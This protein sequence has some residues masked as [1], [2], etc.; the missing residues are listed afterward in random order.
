MFA[1]SDAALGHLVQHHITLT[2]CL[3]QIISCLNTILLRRVHL[4]D[5]SAESG[6]FAIH[7]FCCVLWFSLLVQL[8][9]SWMILIATF[10]NTYISFLQRGLDAL[11]GITLLS[12]CLETV[13]LPTYL[14]V[15]TSWDGMEGF[16]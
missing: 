13:S 3:E 6:R 5:S 4:Q 12:A 11:P 10:S 14:G 1:Y 15:L 2:Y 16:E 7:A 9:Y 8:C